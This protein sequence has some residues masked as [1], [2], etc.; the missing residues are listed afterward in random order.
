MRISERADGVVVTGTLVG[1]GEVRDHG[2][3]YEIALDS[4]WTFRALS[5]RRTDGDVL[6]LRLDDG[7]WRDGGGERPDL[8]GC[9]DI[10]LSGSPLTNTLPIRRLDLETGVP[11][12][13]DMAY[14]ELAQ[15]SVTRDGQIYTRLAPDRFRY[16]AADGGFEAE[17]VVDGDGLVL[18][19]PPLFTRA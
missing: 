14:V 8:E 13:L 15:M 2:F 9:V 19:Y 7:R 4:D 5:L 18:D 10:D 11:R 3:F 1:G 12:R 17:I 6:T 16:Q